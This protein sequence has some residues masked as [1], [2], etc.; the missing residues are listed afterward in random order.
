MR[1]KT[2][3]CPHIGIGLREILGF[4]EK[5]EQKVVKQLTGMSEKARG[6]RTEGAFS[7]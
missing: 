4:P 7:A 2:R 5:E 3:T 6:R 1:H